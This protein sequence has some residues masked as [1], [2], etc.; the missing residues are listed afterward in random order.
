[1]SDYFD[2]K[3]FTQPVLQ[4]LK[5]AGGMRKIISMNGIFSE[6]YLLQVKKKHNEKPH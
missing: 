3:R 1:V 6:W 4:E 5:E 2:F